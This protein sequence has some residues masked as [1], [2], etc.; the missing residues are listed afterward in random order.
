MKSQEM[1]KNTFF[2]L[3]GKYII[4][5]ILLVTLITLLIIFVSINAG[6]INDIDSFV[7]K[8][9][10]IF[11]TP[12]FSNIFL[13]ITYLGETITII[14]LLILC[15]IFLK[16]KSFPLIFLCSI[17]AFINFVIKNLVKRARPM[18]QFVNNLIINYPFPNSYSFPSG[19]SQTSLV[20]YFILA[21]IL[22]NNFYKGKHKKLLLSLSL[23]IPILV[24]LSRLVLGVHFFSDV[25]CGLSI[26]TL[27]IINYFFYLKIKSIKQPMKINSNSNS[28]SNSK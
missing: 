25:L 11:R 24:M 2:K 16:K 9:V 19:H 8:I 7:F 20:F 1:Q 6:F 18:G 23:I 21:F 28:N 17:S 10:E 15:L 22:L 12:V 26:G 5:N 14:I 3:Y 27:I 13:F 4:L